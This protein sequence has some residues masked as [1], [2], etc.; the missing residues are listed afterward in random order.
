MNKSKYITLSLELHLF[1][2][3]IMKEHSLFLEAGFVPVNANFAKEADR[4]KEEFEKLLCHAVKLS[5]GVVRPK[6]L[7]SGEIVTEFTLFSEENT[8]RLSGIKINSD[9]TRQE[10][11][12]RPNNTNCVEACIFHD[13]EALNAKV[14][15]LL[16]ELIEFKENILRNVLTCK[17]YT[18]N[19]PL[20]IEHIIREAKMYR[21]QLLAVQRGFGFDFSVRETELFWDQIMMEHAQFIR[22]LLDPTENKLIKQ[23]HNFAEEF[24]MLIAKTNAVNDRAIKCITQKTLMETQAIR[25]F[26]QAGTIGI[27]ECKIRSI[28]VPLLADHVLR[29]ANHFV[30]IL[31]DFD[32]M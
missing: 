6:V 15:D 8:E 17:M 24:E 30:R 29:E 19:Y 18:F 27:N 25:D 16:E 7:K 3:R 5:D 4:F 1:F 26:K 28:I 14:L 20:L 21:T 32:C 9:I 13:V 22:G 2:A 12:L 10:L 23:A 11:A 31:K